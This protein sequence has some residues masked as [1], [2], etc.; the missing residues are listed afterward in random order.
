MDGAFAMYASQ[1]NKMVMI[2]TVPGQTT[3]KEGFDGTVG[4]Q[5]DP[6]EGLIE[7]TGLEQGTAMRDADFY[8]P[9]VL[10][11]QYPNLFFKGPAKLATF[12]ANGQRGPERDVI[13]LQAPRNR[14][15]RLFYFDAHS[16]LLVRTEERNQADAVT[17]AIEYDDYREVDGIKVPFVLHYIEDTHFIIKLT[18][19]KQNVTIDD[20]V[21]VKPK[22]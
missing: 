16:G 19:V 14:V 8:Q 12:K 6:D 21:F 2:M 15:P 4:W 17:S 18:E 20:A 1:P 11:E 13:V 3:L 7:K 22:K 10:R 9:L 5:Q